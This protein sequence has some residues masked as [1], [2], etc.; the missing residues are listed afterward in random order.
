MRGF[1]L[2]TLFFVLFLIWGFPKVRGSLFGVLIV[3]IL[4]FRVLFQILGSTIFGNSHILAQ[5]ASWHGSWQ[6]PDSLCCCPSPLHATPLKTL[7]S[8]PLNLQPA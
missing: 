4:L 7:N 6:S 8:K 1:E 3:R 5:F 2:Y